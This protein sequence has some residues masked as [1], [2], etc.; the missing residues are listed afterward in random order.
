[1]ER[2]QG[3]FTLVELL[4]AV[5]I[6]V[7]LFGVVGA[8]FT[9][10]LRSQAESDERLA[11]SLDAEFTASYV[12]KDVQSADVVSVTT[13]SCGLGD[14]TLI[15]HLSWTDITTA[16]ADIRKSVAYRYRSAAGDLV[17]TSC[18]AAVP[19]PPQVVARGLTSIPVATH[20]MSSNHVSVRIDGPT[21]ATFRVGGNPRKH[22]GSA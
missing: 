8:A 3:G 2:R 12:T 11:E 20:D 22:G 19:G 16:G 5:S 9:T 18:G 10:S 7:V 15:L 14:G 4:L 1:M 17:R 13:G 21:G 6:S